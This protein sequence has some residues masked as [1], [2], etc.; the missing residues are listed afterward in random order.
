ML[1]QERSGSPG[2]VS[3]ARPNVI[4]KY[5]FPHRSDATGWI[6]K[7]YGVSIK[8]D[9]CFTE[10]NTQ[11]L[12][13]NSLLDHFNLSCDYEINVVYSKCK[14]ISNKSIYICY[15]QRPYI[16]IKMYFGLKL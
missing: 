2:R 4:N 5:L 16:I 8:S 11:T 10:K 12:I 3:R 14:I 7:D 15:K 1:N 6:I 9:L 13:K